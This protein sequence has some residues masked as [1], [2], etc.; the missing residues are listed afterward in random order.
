MRC[1]LTASAHPHQKGHSRAGTTIGNDPHPYDFRRCLCRR[2]SGNVIDVQAIRAS[3]IR[4]GVDPLG[5][6]GVHY[7]PRIAQRYA[8]DLTVIS[9][10]VDPTFA[11]HDARL[12]RPYPH[13]PF[14][15]VSRCNH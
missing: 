3:G 12:G 9:E 5:G 4:M 8:I 2:A 15:V 6:A 7:W 13:G 1:W 11:F 14:V 10:R